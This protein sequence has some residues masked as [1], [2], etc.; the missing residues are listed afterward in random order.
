MQV[1]NTAIILGCVA[2]GVSTISLAQPSGG[3]VVE[4]KGID[5]VGDVGR[6]DPPIGDPGGSSAGSVDRDGNVTMRP[7][8]ITAWPAR[9]QGA[10]AVSVEIGGETFRVSPATKRD[11]EAFIAMHNDP[12][13][14]GFGNLLSLFGLTTPSITLAAIDI[15][16]MVTSLEQPSV[17]TDAWR[18]KAIDYINEMIDADNAAR[19]ERQMWQRLKDVIRNPERYREGIRVTPEGKVM[20]RTAPGERFRGVA[21]D[22][23][24]TEFDRRE[25]SR[26]AEAMWSDRRA[27][28]YLGLT[29]LALG[30]FTPRDGDLTLSVRDQLLINE[31][32]IRMPGPAKRQLAGAFRW[33][34]GHPLAN[35]ALWLKL[36]RYLYR[37]E[38]A[39]DRV[40][41]TSDPDEF[42]LQ[43]DLPNYDD[44][45]WD[46]AGGAVATEGSRFNFPMPPTQVRA[47]VYV[48]PP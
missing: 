38:W 6:A 1:R 22:F 33:N 32:L 12:V 40:I 28:D 48:P 2:L 45:F 46:R 16:G 23:A 27:M 21:G 10:G 43:D 3:G 31:A 37:R 25:L 35:R 17:L 4:P 20:L 30:D 9:A 44:G 47:N 26:L 14:V 34:A 11:L 41:L 36:T 19:S 15:E 8:D 5:I 7:I 24:T 18:A 29:D 39:G 42:G 13:L